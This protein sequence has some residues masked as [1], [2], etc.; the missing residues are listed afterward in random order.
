[1]KKIIKNVSLYGSVTDITVEDGKIAAIGQTDENGVDFSGCR[2]YPGLIDTHSHGCIGRDTMDADLHE[3]ASY[4]LEHGTTT[5]YPT[6]MTMG[7]EDIIR[8]CHAETEFSDGANIPGFHMEGPFINAL[9]KGAQNEKYVIAPSLE[10][11]K[12]AGRVKKITVAP[13]IEGAMEF[14]KECPAVVSI[15]HSDASYD[16]AL[17]AFRAGAKCLTHT[18][19]RMLPML[20]REPGPIPAGA[21]CGAY[22]ELISDGVHVHPA[23]IRL[24]VKL[25]GTDRVVLISDSVPPAG[26]GD[27]RYLL[28]G[29]DITVRD[30]N[31]YTE[32]GNLAGSTTCLFECVRRAI[33]FGIPEEDA[34]KMATKNPADLM[35]INK[36]RIEVGYDADFIIVKDDFRLV[37]A[38]A[39]GDF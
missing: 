23:M 33:G 21:E 34:V 29:L 9:Y 26:L 20:H 32:G 11:F 25:Y 4:Y 31:A 7:E 14:I 16:V 36:G 24:L 39:R 17:E 1:M 12:K 37:K 18:F 2:I 3:M 6:T 38:I 27:G 13:E 30:G 5:W 22:A 15:G 28:G 19:N 35:G 8:A 10:L